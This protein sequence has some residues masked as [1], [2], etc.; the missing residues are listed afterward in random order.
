[1]NYAT[2]LFDITDNIAIITLNRPDRMNAWNDQMAID[3]SHA[4][5]ECNRNDEVRAVV[6]TGADRAF[7]AGADFFSG[8]KAEF[9]KA[10]ADT[11]LPPSWPTVMPWHVK[12][13]A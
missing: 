7:C 6:I 2:I 3:I 13:L 12:K 9:G 1:M 5:S 11:D 8:D 4:L 10:D